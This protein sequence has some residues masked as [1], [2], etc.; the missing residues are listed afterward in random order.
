[1][2]EDDAGRD[3]NAHLTERLER[4]ERALQSQAA[5]LDEIERRLG[6]GRES[7]PEASARRRESATGAAHAAS[8]G[9]RGEIFDGAR[10]VAA[11]ARRR[12][13]ES[14][15]GGSWFNWLGILVLTFG[16]A[17]FLRHAFVR[18]W[19]GPAARVALGG[20]AGLALLFLADR[21]RAR[22]YRQ[23]GYV[24][25][26]G[27]VLILY[28]S[29]Y[30]AHAFFEPPMIEQPAAFLLMSV[31]TAGAVLLSVRHDAQAVAFLA[32]VGGF[33]TPPLLSTGR[34]DEVALFTYVALLDAG[35][36]TLA[37]FKGWRR[38]N[39]LSLFGTIL[40]VLG[41]WITQPARVP[42]RTTFFF[43]TVFFLLYTAAG[44]V[45]SVV[46][47]APA[48][49]T[50]ALLVTTNAAFYLGAGFV[51]L[52]DNGFGHLRAAFALAVAALFGA[53]VYAANA[54]RPDAAP[55]ALAY[56]GAGVGS[57]ASAAG[58]AFEREWVTVSWAAMGGA[59]LAWGY[60]GQVRPARVLGLGLLALTTV[61]V[62]LYDL[63]SLDSLYRVA[64]FVVLGLIL[65]AVSYLYQ[66]T[67][68]AAEPGGD[69]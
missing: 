53:L 45:R 38:L 1:M 54:R 58:V 40:T 19:I 7:A 61:K 18:N 67:Q 50:D 8:D 44:V 57:L 2:S 4:I 25:S 66:K 16:V 36:V 6:A 60:L 17:F 33:L 34:A 12:D 26:G 23:Y 42:L 27:G 55:L 32:L 51:L 21:L 11:A 62:F 43:L 65:L 14:L 41:W 30:A 69:G 48:R 56:A 29:I 35:V 28:L 64:S 24:L 13:V 39:L 20:A 22:G 46:L 68:S 31:V 15:V 63:A 9:R 52:E 47:R 37:Y 3:A 5:R 10:P 59:L 49:W